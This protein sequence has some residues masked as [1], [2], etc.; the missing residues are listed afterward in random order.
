M[1]LATPIFYP[2]AIKIGFI[3]W[4]AA[5]IGLTIRSALLSTGRV[6]RLRGKE[7]NEVPLG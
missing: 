1:I 7:Y 5:L 4:L 3:L 6:E 2:A